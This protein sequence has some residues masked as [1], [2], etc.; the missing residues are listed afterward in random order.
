MMRVAGERSQVS[1]DIRP[2]RRLSVGEHIGGVDSLAYVAGGLVGLWG[3]A[4][5]VPTGRVLAG[6]EPIGADNRR[7]VLQ[8]WLAEASTMWGVATLVLTVTATEGSGAES[9][10]WMYRLIAGLLAALAV[11]TGLTGARTAVIWFKICP[12]VLGVSAVL[13]AVA[14]VA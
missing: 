8:E 14:S 3:V 5:V 10:R 12:V 13:L 6:F 1:R 11:L 9:V 2:Y 4:H 7:V